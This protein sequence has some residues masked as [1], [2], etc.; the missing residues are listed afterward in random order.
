MKTHTFQI[1]AFLLALFCVPLLCNGQLTFDTEGDALSLGND[2]YHLTLDV[3]YQNG[4]IWN[5]ATI[6]LNTDFEIEFTANFGSKDAGADGMAFVLQDDPRGTSAIGSDGGRLG[7][8]GSIQPVLPSI[9]VEFDTYI[10]IGTEGDIGL[11]NDHISFVA[12]ANQSS[13]LSPIVDASASSANIE[14]NVYHSIKISWNSVTHTMSVFFDGVFRSSFSQDIVNLIF[15]GNNAVT[16]GITASTGDYNNLQRVC[17]TSLSE[18]GRS[19]FQQA[20]GEIFHAGGLGVDGPGE[21]GFSVKSDP[22]NCGYVVAGKSLHNT[23]G[24]DHMLVTK[25]FENGSVDWM[26]KF[27]PVIG[28]GEGILQDV[29]VLG[30]GYVATGWMDLD[31]QDVFTMKLDLTGNPIWSVCYGNLNQGAPGDQISYDVEPTPDG[32]FVVVG[33]SGDDIILFKLDANGNRL[34]STVYGDEDHIFEGLSVE[35]TDDDGDG[36]QDNGFAIAGTRRIVTLQGT[37]DADWIV[38]KTDMNGTFSWARTITGSILDDEPYTIKQIDVDGDGLL[39]ADEYIV[40]GYM[41]HPTYTPARRDAAI[42]FLNP[43]TATSSVILYTDG[44]NHSEIRALEQNV[45]GGFILNG[46]INENLTG[47][48]NDVFLIETDLTGS[49]NWDNLYGDADRNDWALSVEEMNSS[50]YVFAGGTTSFPFGDQDIYLVKTDPLGNSPCRTTDGSFS[51]EPFQRNNSSLNLGQENDLEVFPVNLSTPKTTPIF[52]DCSASTPAATSIDDF[53]TI[54]ALEAY[55]TP[56]AQGDILN[57]NIEGLNSF[58][59]VVTN[60]LGQSVYQNK[61][62]AATQEQLSLD[63]RNWSP[64]VYMVVAKTD[65]QVFTQKV[66]IK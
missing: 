46:N 14:D 64:G 40:G 16:W 35:A 42:A 31:Q 4:A 7:Y 5:T 34:W 3:D 24:L 29:E 66:V 51:D 55:P 21:E 32:G 43:A 13:P 30:D 57:V 61:Y 12:N 6:D 41:T 54:N 48:N 19:P 37:S 22:Q 58:E 63:T 33:S 25:T 47:N 60:L 11:T 53:A 10:N 9:A 59:L 52:D 56:L 39:D 18:C 26:S 45:N 2:C 36:V 15:G 50:G 49:P 65:G 20:I 1:P 44:T 27:I 62:E 38:I 28:S 23:L 17:I 8:A